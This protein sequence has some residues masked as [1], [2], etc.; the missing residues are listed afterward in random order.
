M[1]LNK[2]YFAHQIDLL[3]ADGEAPGARRS[4]YLASADR[5][6][7]AIAGLQRTLGATVAPLKLHGLPGGRA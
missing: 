1:D 5:T 2:L 7:V 3:K 6:A 4:R